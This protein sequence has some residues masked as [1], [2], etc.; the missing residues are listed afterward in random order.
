MT[1]NYQQI[2][3]RAGSPIAAGDVVECTDSASTYRT[4]LPT[5]WHKPPLVSKPMVRISNPIHMGAGHVNDTGFLFEWADDPEEPPAIRKRDS[6]VTCG[7]EWMRKHA[8]RQWAA[9]IAAKL[10]DKSDV[11]IIGDA[12]ATTPRVLREDWDK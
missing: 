3:G 10:L 12:F 9:M 6:R 1:V 11:P 7:R 4:F 5:Q 2:K 8:P